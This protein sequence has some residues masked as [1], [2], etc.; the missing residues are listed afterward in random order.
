L[1]RSQARFTGLEAQNRRGVPD[2]RAWLRGKISYVGMARPEAGEKLS[3]QF[4][5][6]LAAMDA[7]QV[8]A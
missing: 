3:R 8:P 1:P 5:S 7:G 6:L 4:E 2:M